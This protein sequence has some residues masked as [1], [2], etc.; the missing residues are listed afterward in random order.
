[1][2]EKPRGVPSYQLVS[3]AGFRHRELGRANDRSCYPSDSALYIDGAAQLLRLGRVHSGKGVYS[4]I[5]AEH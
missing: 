4:K 5:V 1:M 3:V 2:P